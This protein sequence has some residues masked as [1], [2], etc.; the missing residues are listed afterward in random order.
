MCIPYLQAV[1]SE[2]VFNE[3]L[4]GLW[5][6]GVVLVLCGLVLIHH[7]NDIKSKPR[8]PG[9]LPKNKDKYC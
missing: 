8:K 5:W 9:T 4:T 6:I 3:K 7:T 1:V 2:V